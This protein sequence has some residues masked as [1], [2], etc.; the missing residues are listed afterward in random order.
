LEAFTSNHPTSEHQCTSTTQWFNSQSKQSSKQPILLI[1]ND[2]CSRIAATSI[3]SVSRG[4]CGHGFESHSQPYLRTYPELIKAYDV[5]SSIFILILFTSKE[6]S[7]KDFRTKS[8]ITDPRMSALPQLP[9]SVRTRHNF[10]KFF[11]NKKFGRQHLK[12]L[13]PWTNPPSSNR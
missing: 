3:Q 11:C 6:P 13:P 8:K 4:F 1:I 2:F 9:L 12:N 5:L 10:R 7:V